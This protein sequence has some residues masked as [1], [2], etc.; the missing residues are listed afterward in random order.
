MYVP[1]GKQQLS[2]MLYRLKHEWGEPIQWLR[3]E[4]SNLNIDT[5]E[6]EESVKTVSIPRAIVLPMDVLQKAKYSITYL[7][8]NKNFV[9]DGMYETASLGVLLDLRDISFRDFK[10]RN[11]DRIVIQDCNE[12]EIHKIEYYNMEIGL[13]I[14]LKKV[15]NG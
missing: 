9:Y 10:D 8:S 2:E 13:I 12:Y 11:E 1:R 7:A 14:E 3:R 4:A 15:T 6:M 5:G